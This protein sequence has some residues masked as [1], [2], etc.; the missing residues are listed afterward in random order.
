MIA[1]GGR[2][3]PTNYG[4]TIL[5]VDPDSAWVVIF[6]V[7]VVTYFAALLL[8]KLIGRPGG[9]ASG[10]FLALP[11][12]LPL[13][14]AVVYAGS[15]LP[16][17]GVLQPAGRALR[18]RSG[19]L[20]HLLLLADS[21]E[22]VVTPY[23]L[24]GSAGSWILVVGVAVSSFMLLRRV[25]GAIAVRRLVS[26]CTPLP[27]L[28]RNRVALMVE[29]LALDAGL[30]K[31][32]EVMLLPAGTPGAFAAGSRRSRV[33]LAPELLVELDSSE[34]EA[35]LAHEIAHLEARDCQVMVGAGFLRDLVAWNPIAH[36]SY[37]HL[38]NDRELEAD[39][40]A[41]SLTGQPLAVA[42]SLLKVCEMVKGSKLR[43]RALVSFLRP[44]SRIKRRVTNL[45]A[46]AD[47]RTAVAPPHHLPYAFA[48]VLLVVIGLQAG[49]RIAA[50]DASA[51]AIM[52]GS[53]ST[54]GDN[55]DFRDLYRR[56][57]QPR[58]SKGVDMVKPR[59]YSQ[60][61]N[62]SVKNGDI[63]RWMQAMSKWASTQDRALVRLRWESRQDWRAVPL[64]SETMGPFDIYTI[65]RQPL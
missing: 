14:A 26:R 3:V 2:G 31:A 45:L 18:E 8:R 30:K 61:A 23:A 17:V 28:I 20:L 38:M 21:S 7:S 39:R 43:H 46:L 34:L 54:P 22:G 51:L 4:P 32:P 65:K 6:G 56:L 5:S 24:S 64:F 57:K 37:H 41:A 9:L 53:P 25:V 19:E 15:A 50:E 36:L 16:E 52:W 44:G 35:I 27:P 1:G 49:A 11:L 59:H 58:A 48:A 33:L 10:L 62:G 13:C 47:G 29:R 42:S 63:G 55:T 60:L 12:V 40:R